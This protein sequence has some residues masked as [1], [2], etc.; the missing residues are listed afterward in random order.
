MHRLIERVSGINRS[1]RC[2][3][4]AAFGLIALAPAI[5]LARQPADDG[6]VGKRVVQKFSNFTLRI[7]NQVV[8]R[9]GKIVEFYRVEQTNGPWLWL[10]AEGEGLNGWAT[11]DQVVP[12]EQGI[13]F[14]T[15]QVRANPQDAFSY[16]MRALLWRDKKELDIALADFSEA[17]RLDPT[18]AWVYNDR[19]LAW[20]DKKE[21]DKAIADYNEAIRL[22]PQD[23]L[24]H[25][26]RGIA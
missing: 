15:N 17:I 12:V 19:G 3:W 20:Y 18:H 1:G 11:A 21:Y 25:N 10:K 16:V 14:F 24:A 6:W 2:V 9:S 13:A 7:G 23:A 26:N 22:D 8:D 5:S 4:I